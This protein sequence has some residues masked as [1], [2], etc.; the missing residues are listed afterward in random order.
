MRAQSAVQ[1]GN[2]PVS[3]F[4]NVEID[5][6]TSVFGC[7]DRQSRGARKKQPLDSVS[8]ELHLY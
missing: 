3:T 5:H 7:Y 2:C 4:S 8:S 6:L 1:H